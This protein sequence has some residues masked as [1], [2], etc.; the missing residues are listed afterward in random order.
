MSNQSHRVVADAPRE[1]VT[2]IIEVPTP[3]DAPAAAEAAKAKP[4]KTT[5]SPKE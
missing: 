3:P 1:A 5:P 4:D 2:T